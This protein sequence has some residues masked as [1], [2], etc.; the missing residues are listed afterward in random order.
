[1][2]Q[3]TLDW[4][5]QSYWLYWE[6]PVKDALVVAKADKKTNEVHVTCDRS[7]RGLY[8]LVDEKLL[9]PKKEIAVFLQDKEV[10]RGLVQPSLAT[11]L[12][13]GARGDP[14]LVYSARIPLF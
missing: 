5:W 14:E 8:V 11:I 13:T 12:A 3:P 10:F 4:K 2:W 7:T 9:D 1:M 6:E